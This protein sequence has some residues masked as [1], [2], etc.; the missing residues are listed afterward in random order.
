MTRFLFRYSAEDWL[1]QYFAKRSFHFLSI[2]RR[3]KRP[4]NLTF[5]DWSAGVG[6][7]ADYY[8]DVVYQD[9]DNTE[10][11]LFIMLSALWNIFVLKVRFFE[12]VEGK[13][14]WVG[15]DRILSRCAK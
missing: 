5:L 15:L 6:S 8:F 1:K 11:K 13:M 10:R 12:E 9:K 4:R 3:K 14:V 7:E 2:E